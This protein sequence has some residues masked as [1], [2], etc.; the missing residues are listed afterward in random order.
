MTL[1]PVREAGGIAPDVVLAARNIEKSFGAVRALRSVNF[2]V[3][4][5]QVTTLFG[6]NG[7][8]KS[9][10][11]KIL[12]GVLTP[13]AGE[14]ILDGR[15]V[16]IR[17]TIEARAL[18]IS[19]IHQELSLAPN[20]NVRD[21]IFLGREIMGRTGVYYAEEERRT[22]ALMKELVEDID[23]LALVGDLRL[24]QQQIVEIARALSINSRILIMDE[25][26]SALSASEVTVL[27]KVIRD[28]KA[29]GVSIVYISHHLEE[30]LT[31][32]DHAVVLRDAV[33]TAAA[34]RAEIDL[35]WIVRNMVGENFDLGQPPT[36]HEIGAPALEVKRLTVDTAGGA[37]RAVDGLDLTV[38]AGEVVCIYGLMGAGRTELMECV[39]GRIPAASGQVLLHGRDIGGLSIADRIAAGLALV[40]EDRQ[41]DGLVQTISVGQN[42]SLASIGNFTRRLLTDRRAERAIVDSSI[43]EVTVKTDGP[44]APIGSL[45]GGNQ[46]KVVIGK[47]LATNPS[48][49]LLDEPSRGIDIGAKGEVFRILADHARQG[50]AVVYTTSEV[51]ECLA[52]AHRIIVMRRGRIVA[53]FTH[54]TTKEAIM[55]ASGESLVA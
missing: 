39:A 40:P 6:E 26:T 36:G 23:P 17:S 48:V 2:D 42:L 12:A 30:A 50:M 15:P 3:H 14:L 45:S 53:E 20:M 51:G 25:P 13:T 28:L 55:A 8:G 29:R 5:G 37:V 52:I 44:D 27:F 18:G 1:G 49:L 47:M 34:P 38:R 35:E 24:G 43:R 22:R 32:T 33:M 21:N 16:E 54:D 11:M 4:R 9:T 7:A 10:L 31:I 19:I 41:R 46:Q